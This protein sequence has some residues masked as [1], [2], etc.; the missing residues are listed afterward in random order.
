[1][2][3]AG[4]DL[5]AVA[6]GALLAQATLIQIRPTEAAARRQ[7]LAAIQAGYTDRVDLLP[8]EASKKFRALPETANREVPYTIGVPGLSG[9]MAVS[10]GREHSL[11]LLRDGTVRAWGRNKFG[12]LGDGT[13]TDRTTPVVVTGMANAV[14]L[15]AGSSFSAVLLADGT[16]I[17]WGDISREEIGRRAPEVNPLPV[18]VLGVTDIRTIAVGY[19]HVLALTGAGTVVSWGS[20]PGG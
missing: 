7:L 10:A 14:A 13:T 20:E 17:T 2:L 11:A 6:V 16:I 9:V 4:T 12:Q 19:D 15:C 5:V 18:P 1:M 3:I 8:E